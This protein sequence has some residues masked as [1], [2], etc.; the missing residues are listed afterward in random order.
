MG[1]L[2]AKSASAAIVERI[3]GKS[4]CIEEGPSCFE[5]PLYF[6]TGRWPQKVL[7]CFEIPQRAKVWK[8]DVP[9][10]VDCTAKS[11]ALGLNVIP[12]G[13]VLVKLIEAANE[14]PWSIE[15]EPPSKK[16]K[17]MYVKAIFQWL[18]E[19]ISA[20]GLSTTALTGLA[21][22]QFTIFL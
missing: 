18:L 20:F 11:L 1:L 6:F 14:S 2:A 21:L 9:S 7:D 16:A 22:A 15:G 8:T 5:A 4:Y 10:L 3:T 19:V 12:F 13:S 17:A